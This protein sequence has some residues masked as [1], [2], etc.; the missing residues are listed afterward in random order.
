MAHTRY[1]NTNMV[2]RSFSA[3]ALCLVICLMALPALAFSP[4]E[5]TLAEVVRHN[6]GPF[7]SWEVELTYPEYPDV[8]TRLWYARGKWRQEWRYGEQAK[9]LG[10]GGSVVASCATEGFPLSPMLLWMVPNPVE[11]WRSWGVDMETRNFGFCNGQPCLML[12]A[13]PGD[14]TSPAVRLN[15][16]SM[17]PILIRYT[18]DETLYSVHFDEYKTF[19][20]Y[21]VPQSVSVTIGGD[22]VLQMQVKWIAANKADDPSLYAM[23]AF[24]ATP[25]LSPPLPFV[26]LRDHFHYPTAP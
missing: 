16:E 18:V 12:G 13:E 2:M 14:E 26:L 19:A 24:D 23:D 3:V 11:A 25:C 5:E 21:E 4:D 17:A 7:S 1:D 8:S 6:Y 20:G 15:N 9:G 10:V 22:Q